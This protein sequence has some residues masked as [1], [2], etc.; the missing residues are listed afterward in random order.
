V[1][2]P[3]L[4]LPVSS[5]RI[6]RKELKNSE[7]SGIRPDSSGF[8]VPGRQ[9]SMA[10]R[11]RKHNTRKGNTVRRLI[12]VLNLPATSLGCVRTAPRVLA[13]DQESFM[14]QLAFSASAPVVSPFRFDQH[15]VRVITRNGEPWF[16]ASDIA[17]ALGYRNAGDAARSLA[18]HQKADTQIVRSSSNGTEQSRS[19]TII[20]ESG[21]YRLV[22]RSRKPEAERFSDWVT[23]EVLPAI[24]KTGRYEQAATAAPQITGRWCLSF[25]PEG[26]QRLTP[27]PDR[28]VMIDPTN[29]ADLRRLLTECVPLA[30]VPAVLEIAS[31]RV[32]NQAARALKVAA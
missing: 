29:P 9:L 11:G 14:H 13:L 5:R 21:L 19:V 10:G 18:D 1:S 28:A 8:F 12:S 31:A 16:V 32:L 17:E 27:I 4:T 3:T 6:R 7:I 22:L 2:A 26:A 30:L 23:G 24:R 20:N 25:D 15:D